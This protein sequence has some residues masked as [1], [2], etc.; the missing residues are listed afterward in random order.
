MK[1]ITGL[2]C[3]NCG[4]PL[5]MAEG[6]K[7]NFCQYCGQRLRVTE[8]EQPGALPEVTII[9]PKRNVLDI[10]LIALGGVWVLMVLLVIIDL[11]YWKS[12]TEF[13]AALLLA[14]PGIVL[15]MIGLRR[16]KPRV[17]IEGKE[18]PSGSGREGTRQTHP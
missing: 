16:K 10:I 5:Q 6:A 12:A 11:Q 17:L 18:H 15:L 13:L 1:H 4:A 14:A 9:R 2:H 3:P 8:K 7:E